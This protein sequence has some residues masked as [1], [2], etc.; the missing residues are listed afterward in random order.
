MKSRGVYETPGG[1]I[2]YAAHRELESLCLDRETLHFKEQDGPALRGI[3]LLRHVVPH[4]ARSL[5]A[6]IDETQKTIRRLGQAQA[7]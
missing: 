4:P 6:F 5:Q 1:T 7:L 2:L 3:G